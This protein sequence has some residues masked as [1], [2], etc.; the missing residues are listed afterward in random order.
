MQKAT[1]T[2]IFAALLFLSGCVT[3]QRCYEKYGRSRGTVTALATFNQTEERTDLQLP[4]DFFHHTDSLSW[5][6]SDGTRAWIKPV[7]GLP[8]TSITAFSE[9][10]INEPA[11]RPADDA[12]PV[13]SSRKK[14]IRRNNARETETEPDRQN[15]HQ[16]TQS[17]IQPVLKGFDVGL[18]RPAK[19][20]SVLVEV[21]CPPCIPEPCQREHVKDGWI[22]RVFD[23]WKWGYWVIV[24]AFIGQIIRA[25]FFVIKK[26]I[27]S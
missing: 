17:S 3:E 6:L 13:K 24:G 8:D 7:W 12:K 19:K 20:D 1:R 9:Y 21:D 5:Q 11:I 22:H 4:P 16:Q 25:L 2:V 14:R 26:V 10:K 18:F 15:S 27:I 23:W